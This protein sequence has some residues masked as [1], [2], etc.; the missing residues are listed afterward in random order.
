MPSRLKL[1]GLIFLICCL[2]MFAFD[3]PQGKKEQVVVPPPPQ[4]TPTFS[5]ESAM[6]VVDVTVRDRKGNLVENLKREDFKVYE[7]N[8]LQSIVTFSAEKVA[9]GPGAT[10]QATIPSS[11]DTAAAPI[12]VPAPA[13][14]LVNLGL[15]P[16][17]PVKKEVLAG[18]RLMILFF[19]LSMDSE[20]LTRSLDG[21]RDFL[22][23]Q[24]GPQDLVAVATYQ[25]NLSLDQDFTNDR[26][27]LLK[28]IAKLNTEAS[29][30]TTTED[31][32]DASTSDDVYVP[33]NVQFDIFNT[34]RRMAALE[35]LAK[36][37]REFPE[38][39]SLIYFSGGVSTTGV[40]NNAQIRATVDNANRSNMSIYTVDSRGLQA[41]PPGG[42]ASQASAGSAMF[43]GGAMSRQR[44]NMASSQ[45][46]MFTLSHDTGGRAFTDSNDLTLAMK[47]VQIDTNVYYVIGYFTSNP[48]E[49][50]KYRKIRV[51]LTQQAELKYK[52]EH[53]SGYF[54]AKSFKQQNKEEKDFQL[55]Q[56][57]NVDRP[58][59][60]VPL[61]L[62]A[63][64]F[65]K[66]NDV[67]YVPISIEL[68]GDGLQFQ[69][70]GDNHEGKFEFIAQAVDA[71]GKVSGVAR[72]SV[73]LKLPNE[74]AKR[75]KEGGIFY[76][77]GFELKP[78]S[79]K[80]KFLVR[81]NSSGKLGSFE[82][83]INVPTIDLKKLTTSSIVL[84]NQLANTSADSGVS[85]QGSM[86]QFQE[87][88]F[89]FNYD[90][91]VMGD[92]KVVPSIG[93][94]FLSRQT[95]YVYFNVYG[96]TEDHETKKPC[97]ETDLMLIRDNTKILE[98]QPQYVQ[99]WT[100][101][102][103]GRGFGGGRGPGGGGMPPDMAGRGGPGG[104]GRMG[105]PGGPGGMMGMFPGME[106]TGESTVAISLP[107]KDLKKGTYVLQ[108]H[109]RDVIAD[110]N[111]F[112]RVPIVI[113]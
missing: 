38:R 109:V 92:K 83:P 50:G 4:R 95:V 63:D 90:P 37:Y 104:G 62:Q 48:K 87:R 49:D 99:E 108:V 80:M 1:F 40:E 8:A 110:T 84:A 112:Q 24:T 16:S 105:G 65:R 79:Y 12:P 70:K 106:R 113:Q 32:S 7:D 22:E 31:L 2:A 30:D 33:D 18:K 27:L 67:V 15:N 98:T 101:M 17:A 34:D 75:I 86:R 29:S 56:A 66:D 21:A 11:T 26:A 39:K 94:V 61:I 51:E 20:T 91:L 6:V 89:G 54:A 19:D 59:V 14:E 76:S 103:F 46:T 44:S 88:G 10:T 74:K 96:A 3:T 9:I 42:N 43:G 57:M 93:N 58:F 107:L 5:V 36:M 28:T 85:H 55:Q 78:G 82:Q 72:D 73:S 100:S 25:T 97:V 13:P 77:T 23:K 53:R 68:A 102:R 41:S 64:Y 69:E 52:I 45:E 47:Q 71:K 81:D 35:T 111:H 60:D